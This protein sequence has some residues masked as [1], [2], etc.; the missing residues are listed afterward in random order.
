MDSLYSHS[1]HGVYWYSIPRALYVT[2]PPQ[3]AHLGK[4]AQVVTAV[5][6]LTYLG[7]LQSEHT[8]MLLQHTSMVFEVLH[9]HFPVL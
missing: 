2:T 5:V 3:L 6:L 4:G 7:L 1:T 8:A 9:M